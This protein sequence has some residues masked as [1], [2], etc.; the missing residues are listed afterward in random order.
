[1]ERTQALG[2]RPEAEIPV[3]SSTICEAADKSPKSCEISLKFLYWK[4][5]DPSPSSWLW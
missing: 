2:K 5:R 3:V 4:D 1:M